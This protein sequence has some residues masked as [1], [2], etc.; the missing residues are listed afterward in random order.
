MQPNTIYH[1]DCIT[2]LKEHPKNT[3]DLIYLDP[4]FFS[5]KNYG[6]FDD[7]WKG[8]INNYIAWMEPK[9]RECH[10]VLKE[11]GS[12]YLHCDWHANA[13]LRI[14]MDK[15]FGENNFRNEIIW[16]YTR[17]GTKHQKQFP[18]VHDNILYYSKGD[19]WTFNLDDI[20]ITYAKSTIERGKYSVATS[21]VTKGIKKR[22]LPKKGK[23]PE[24]YW[25]IP[26]IQ[27]N[28]RERLG[29]PTQKPEKLLERIIK[30][31][32]NPMDIVLDPMCGGGTTIAVA[33]RLGRRWIGI[34]ISPIAY[35]ISRKRLEQQR[36]AF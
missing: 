24:D 27:G 2:Y 28:A 15:I 36:I 12:F 35:E 32:S 5:N 19:S 6:D 21:K 20:R 10:R 11:T 13:Y 18:R 17:P 26:M 22:V 23:S 7:R 9:I 30:V 29:Y 14:L 3:I 34:D 1:G 33:Q 4:P 16:C 8:G 25:M 31:S